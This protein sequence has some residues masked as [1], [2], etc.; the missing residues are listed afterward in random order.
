[1]TL[2]IARL[3]TALIVNKVMLRAMKPNQRNLDLDVQYI[4]HQS[5]MIVL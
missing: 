1:M 5:T 2:D 4:E 3:F